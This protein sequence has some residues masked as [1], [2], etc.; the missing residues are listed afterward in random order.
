MLKIDVYSVRRAIHSNLKTQIIALPLVEMDISNKASTIYLFVVNAI[1]HARLVLIQRASAPLAMNR[2]PSLQM[3][4]VSSI[5]QLVTQKQMINVKH[6]KTHVQHVMVKLIDA[7]LV[8]ILN[9]YSKIL[10]MVNV[11]KVPSHSWIVP[12]I[13]SCVCNA[14]MAVKLVI[15]KGQR[16]VSAVALILTVNS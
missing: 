14:L 13:S 4:S 3:G 16:F 8:L 11:Q 5:V 10:A 1:H 6:V 2:N 15:A 7:Y 12:Q 9:F